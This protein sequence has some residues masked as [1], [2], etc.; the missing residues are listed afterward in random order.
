MLLN[1]YKISRDEQDMFALNSQEKTQKAISKNKFQEEIIKL[2][3]KKND[4]NF[5][6]E[7]DEHPRNNLTL[8]TL[9]NLL[10][11][12]LKKKVELLQQEILQDLMMEQQ[13]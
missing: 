4:K 8:K 2:Q 5:I 10:K 3:I 6:F 7:K 9:K 11:A 13:Q 12:F 1:K